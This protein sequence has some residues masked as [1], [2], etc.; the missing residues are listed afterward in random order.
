MTLLLYPTITYSY[1]MALVS[2]LPS[3]SDL[4]VRLRGGIWA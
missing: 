2:P 4:G 3:L 1:Y